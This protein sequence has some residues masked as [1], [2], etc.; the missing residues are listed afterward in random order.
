M[1]HSLVS[2]RIFIFF[3]LSLSLAFN[4]TQ[5]QSYQSASERFDVFGNNLYSRQQNKSH[6]IPNNLRP[7]DRTILPLKTLSNRQK[8]DSNLEQWKSQKEAFQGPKVGGG[9][10]LYLHTSF[11]HLK[12]ILELLRSVLSESQI[13]KFNNLIKWSDS[14]TSL[15]DGLENIAVANAQNPNDSS[16]MYSVHDQ[17]LVI[18]TNALDQ[19]NLQSPPALAVLLVTRTILIGLREMLQ[20]SVNPEQLENLAMIITEKFGSCG[21]T[22]NLQERIDSCGF[23][24]NSFPNERFSLL[25]EDRGLDSK[26]RYEI[27]YQVLY[28]KQQNRYWY[29]Q[30]ALFKSEDFHQLQDICKNLTLVSG[31]A[32]N[33]R[34]PSEKEAM[35]LTGLD[36]ITSGVPHNL[37]FFV[38]DSGLLFN[39]RS[40]QISNPNLDKTLTVIS[41]LGAFAINPAVTLLATSYKANSEGMRDYFFERSISPVCVSEQSELKSQ[42]T[43]PI[44]ISTN[45]SIL[46]NLKNNFLPTDPTNKVEDLIHETINRFRLRARSFLN[47]IQENISAEQALQKMWPKI[48]V[49]TFK[50]I[51]QYLNAVQFV[52]SHL[53]EFRSR[54][55]PRVGHFEPLVMDFL[56]PEPGSSNSIGQVFPTASMITKIKNHPSLMSQ[57]DIDA[58]FFVLAFHELSHLIGIGLEDD[59]DSKVFANFIFNLALPTWD[60]CGAGEANWLDAEEV[61]KPQKQ[62]PEWTLMLRNTKH[63]DGSPITPN[64]IQFMVAQEKF[65]S[66]KS[67]KIYY[68]IGL[69]NQLS[70]KKAQSLCEER[71]L[72]LP[73]LEESNE[74]YQNGPISE[75]LFSF[76]SRKNNE[77]I[78][79]NDNQ[80]RCNEKIKGENTASLIL[81]KFTNNKSVALICTDR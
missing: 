77:C 13:S 14:L 65:K 32:S 71:G 11:R 48:K 20:L 64:L 35:S 36:W 39:L 44:S 3:L 31:Q 72:R 21:F 7:V 58:E 74:L 43:D 59:Q 38:G 61:C 69:T 75:H 22:G 52:P 15:R 25:T 30:P 54:F 28:D 19:I 37:Q 9:G 49:S 16:L 24:Q 70:N 63:I 57:D 62:I 80:I 46:K 1:L 23:T 78:Y 50:E 47:R 67:N 17:L 26:A 5:A 73:T 18:E 45:L 12:T 76:Q 81:Q 51:I 66:Q 42:Y 53:L 33:W 79:I 56:M 27:K 60:Q 68:Y 2:M 40:K 6:V 55:N 4:Q 8:Q 29:W 34:M 41:T 10:F